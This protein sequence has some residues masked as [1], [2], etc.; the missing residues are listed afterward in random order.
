M[1]RLLLALIVAA[2]L[3]VFA[4]PAFA[5]QGKPVDPSLKIDSSTTMK[6]GNK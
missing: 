6:I 3:A 4:V 1:K 5:N 2:L